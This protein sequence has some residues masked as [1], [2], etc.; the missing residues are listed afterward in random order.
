MDNIE[1][2]TADTILQR[3]KPIDVAGKTYEV[4]VIT[5]ATIALFSEQI[6][7]LDIKNIEAKDFYKSLFTNAHK[8]REIAKALAILILGANKLLREKPI[9]KRIKNI[10]GIDELKIL[11]NRIYFNL[12]IEEMSK[13]F[14]ELVSELQP[15][16]FFSLIIFLNGVS[17]TKPTKMTA[18]GQSLEDLLNNTQA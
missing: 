15:T 6:A 13:L 16:V 11:T 3:S 1:K 10:L 7:K 4:P 12:P 18:S 8:S 17:A 5:G 14:D 2:K 9:K